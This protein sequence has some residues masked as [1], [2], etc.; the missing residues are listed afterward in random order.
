MDSAQVSYSTFYR[1][2]LAAFSAVWHF[3][4]QK[5]G[6][7]FQLWTD[8]HP[9]TFA[10][11]HFSDVWTPHKQRQLSYIVEYTSDIL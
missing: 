7:P 2:L 9:L 1:E 11:G 6:R 4:F 10:L 8:H 3:R 5:E